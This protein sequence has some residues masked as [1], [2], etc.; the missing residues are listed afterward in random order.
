MKYIII[1]ID[2]VADYRIAELGN[3]TPLQYAKTPAM[4]SIAGNGEMGIVKTI[5]DGMVPGSDTANLSVL[6]YDPKKYHT[7]R[8][9]LEAVSLGIDLSEDDIVFRCNLVTLSEED[10]YTDRTMVDY[11]AGEIPTDL[12]R[13]LIRDIGSKL[14][15]EKI[16]FFPGVSYRHI[17]VWEGGPD[18]NILTPP[19]DILD[20]KIS[21]FLSRGPGSSALLDMMVRS[22]SLLKEHAINKERVKK[23]IRPANSIWIWGEGRKPALDSFYD[24]YKLEGSVISA[25]DL[26]KGIGIL[27]GLTPVRVEGATGTIHTNFKG[28]ASAAIGQ[29]TGGKNF[30]YLHLEAPDECSHQGNVKDKV[31]SIEIIDREVIGPIKEALGRQGFD[32]KMMILPDHYTPVSVRTHTSEPVPFLIYDSSRKADSK[33]ERFDE[34]T[35]K[36]TGL[37]FK[38]GYK[39][40]D[41]FFGIS[42]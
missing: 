27:A 33:S 42:T 17:I 13:I 30:V 25:V 10:D 8:S 21:D 41:Y 32:Y 36:R 23:G 31:K 18:N 11:S 12:S 4:D 34:F 16:K 14:Q 38:E 6:G 1:L 28:K 19:H 37:Y 40:A 35:A 7:G 20:K 3:K 15:T 24:K 22:S 39:L 29:L 2:G 9:P 5:P 26:I